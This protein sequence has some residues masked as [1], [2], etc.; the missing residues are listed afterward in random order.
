[1]NTKEF[2]PFLPEATSA[3]TYRE[4]YN[5]FG[6]MS[7]STLR[8]N[9]LK[10]TNKKE[11]VKVWPPHP[12]SHTCIVTPSHQKMPWEDLPCLNPKGMLRLDS[13]LEECRTW[14]SREKA[15]GEERVNCRVIR[16]DPGGTAGYQ[17]HT[18]LH[19]TPKYFGAEWSSGELPLENWVAVE[20]RQASYQQPDSFLIMRLQ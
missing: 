9:Q 14:A 4:R 15:A 16:G 18:P 7:N 19:T 17:W 3:W 10:Q 1:M 5:S 11:L 12:L 8:N 20:Q 13:P 6:K 2:N